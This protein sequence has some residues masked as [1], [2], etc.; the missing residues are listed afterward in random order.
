MPGPA[1]CRSSPSKADCD[2]DRSR[3]D[4][5]AKL[6]LIAGGQPADSACEHL[7]VR[8]DADRIL[9]RFCA[10]QPMPCPGFRP[11]HACWPSV[12]IIPQSSRFVNVDLSRVIDYSMK[13]AGFQQSGINAPW[14]SQSR[15]STK[16]RSRLS[17]RRL[18]VTDGAGAY[19]LPPAVPVEVTARV[20]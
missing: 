10:G 18:L 19:V 8:T 4:S 16:C 15:Q 2:D 11:A 1:A 13:G 9:G 5:G 20:E 3:R 17:G 6:H 14:R 12:R 7:T